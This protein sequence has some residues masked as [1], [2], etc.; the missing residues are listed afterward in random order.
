MLAA[1]LAAL[2]VTT[3][4]VVPCSVASETTVYVAQEIAPG[5]YREYPLLLNAGD[6]VEIDLDI[7]SGP[8]A[9]FYFVDATGHDEFV[10]IWPAGVGGF[11]AFVEELSEVQSDSV[12]K[13]ALAP[14]EGVFYLMISNNDT[15]QSSVVQGTIRASA[16]IP[17]TLLTV[18]LITIAA[19]AVVVVVVAILIGRSLRA[20]ARHYVPPGQP[21]P[22]GQTHKHATE[23][24]RPVV[25]QTSR[26][27]PKCGAEV[28]RGTAACASCGSRF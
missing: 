10:G 17:G 21:I 28:P 3:L 15:S 8:D 26:T 22:Q 2:I 1:A 7:Q 25:Q 20:K 19:I 9:G 18:V 14:S 23:G 24:M 12:H 16:Q 6:T 11:S 4:G 5:S 13:S 27:C